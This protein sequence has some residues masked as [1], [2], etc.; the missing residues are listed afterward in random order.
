MC[1]HIHLTP[2]VRRC[3]IERVNG[4]GV[5]LMECA[6]QMMIRN[7]GTNNRFCAVFLTKEWLIDNDFFIIGDVLFFIYTVCTILLLSIN[8]NAINLK[9]LSCQHNFL[10]LTTVLH[11]L[12]VSSDLGAFEKRKEQ[13]SDN[14]DDGS[15]EAEEWSHNDK[16]VEHV[17]KTLREGDG[18]KVEEKSST[19]EGFYL[20][21]CFFS[22]LSRYFV[23]FFD[24]YIVGY[25]YYL[26]SSWCST[27][28]II[29]FSFVLCMCCDGKQALQ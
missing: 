3:R 12:W 29:A 19:A 6:Y 17:H 5:L 24:A 28:I 18:K 22:L 21:A 25:C 14:V 26:F 9:L 23:V 4:K 16:S 10:W 8:A 11:S 7:N 13:E 15:N 20:H 2:I 1:A 27:R